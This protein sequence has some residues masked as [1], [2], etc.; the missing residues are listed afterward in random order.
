MTIYLLKRRFNIGKLQGG[1][2]SATTGLK[3]E[4]SRGHGVDQEGTDE[5]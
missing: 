5:L 1:G 2:G 3:K 4:R